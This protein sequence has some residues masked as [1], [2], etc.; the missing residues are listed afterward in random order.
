MPH[1]E[2][3][4]QVIESALRAVPKTVTMTINGRIYTPPND[5]KLLRKLMAL[6]K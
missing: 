4:T 5:R 6:Q 2:Y 3:V 1:P